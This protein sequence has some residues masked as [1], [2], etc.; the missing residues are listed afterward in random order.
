[1]SFLF[2]V[3]RLINCEIQIQ[4]CNL[5]SVISGFPVIVGIL[6]DQRDDVEMVLYLL[7]FICLL[8]LG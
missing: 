2:S 8:F 7:F 6:K 3:M 1:M 4:S 5:H